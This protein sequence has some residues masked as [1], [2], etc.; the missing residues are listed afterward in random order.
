LIASAQDQPDRR[1]FALELGANRNRRGA[2]GCIMVRVSHFYSIDRVAEMISE[3][4][5]LLEEIAIT[6]D[7]ADG[8]VTIWTDDDD[9]ITAFS[10]DGVD[11]LKELIAD[12]RTEDGGIRQYLIDCKC[13]NDTIARIMIDELRS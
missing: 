5:E 11:V 8:M 1:T 2:R 12:I 4:V 10:D 7:D 6:L 13:E 9:S 3:N